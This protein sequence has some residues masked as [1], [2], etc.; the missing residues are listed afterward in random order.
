MALNQLH[1][2]HRFDYVIFLKE[3]KIECQG[4]YKE[5]YQSNGEFRELI[6]SGEQAKS[7]DADN[8][9]DKTANATEADYLHSDQEA[10]AIAFSNSMTK[11]V[12][13]EKIKEKLSKPGRVISS[14][15]KRMKRN[16]IGPQAIKKDNTYALLTTIMVILIKLMHLQV[17]CLMNISHS[18]LFS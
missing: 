1:F 4:S 8:I 14:P 11:L 18:T 3:G 13:K 5:V 9:D 7:Q 6:A 16:H 15:K 2:V 12:E 17:K 10:K